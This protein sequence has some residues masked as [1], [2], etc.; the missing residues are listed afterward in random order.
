MHGWV[1]KGDPGE[2]VERRVERRVLSPYIYPLSLI[3]QTFPKK[4]FGKD[5]H[6]LGKINHF[7]SK[8]IRDDIKCNKYNVKNMSL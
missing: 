6:Y 5:N 4:Y 8:G 7:F 2:G 3:S 1:L